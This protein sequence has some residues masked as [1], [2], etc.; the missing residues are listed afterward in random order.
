MKSRYF[1]FIALLL[2][3]L[4]SSCAYVDIRAPFD[5]DLDQTELG[6]KVGRAH[7]YSVLWLFAW[8]D[9]SYEAAARNG[10]IKIMRHADQE[11]QQYLFGL[12]Y[13]RTIIV[14]GD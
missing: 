5:T 7:T 4:T 11:I 8:G 12:Y 6:S 1:V 10:N 2:F 3:L 14:Y 9:G 13:K